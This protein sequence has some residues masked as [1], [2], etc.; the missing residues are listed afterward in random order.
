[1]SAQDA[2]NRVT[3]FL[4]KHAEVSAYKSDFLLQYEHTH[5]ALRVSDL[6]TLIAALPETHDGP[7]IWFRRDD[8][9]WHAVCGLEVLLIDT[10]LMCECGATNQ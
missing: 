6:R 2:A 3:A 5:Y 1:M 8:R 7:L 10:Y 4:D 9:M